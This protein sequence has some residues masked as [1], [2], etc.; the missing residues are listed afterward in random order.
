MFYVLLVVIVVPFL[1]YLYITEGWLT[2][3]LGFL[4]VA[5]FVLL[6]VI[7]L[8]NVRKKNPKTT[9]D[10]FDFQLGRS[11]LGKT[12]LV[13]ELFFQPIAFIMHLFA[14]QDINKLEKNMNTF[15]ILMIGPQA[16]GKGTQAEILSQKFN[17]PIFSTGNILRQKMRAQDEL[18]QKIEKLINN[19][20]LVPDEM[21]NEIVAE[22]IKTDGI[23]GY[24]LDGYP[25]NMGQV[26]F[27]S[28][29]DD[30]THVFEIFISDREAMAR[31]AGR[32]TCPKCQKAYNLI[33]NPP[34]HD[35]RCD[36]CGVELYVR[37][38]EKEEVVKKR[39]ATYHELT[40]SILDFY[41]AQGVY[42]RIDGE[43][44]ISEVERAIAEVLGIRG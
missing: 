44:S 5:L 2:F 11:K 3:F 42:H 27:F 4:G 6:G 25:R 20:V 31:I 24:I 32:R 30:L 34:Q 39:L 29:V 43:K 1:V 38:D 26:Q 18:G 14:I 28:K 33:S 19:G 23:N 17:L 21:V 12:M 9:K 22:K 15:K 36:D 37:E 41:K 8:N 13:Y 16:S 40:E 35:N 7:G 10:S